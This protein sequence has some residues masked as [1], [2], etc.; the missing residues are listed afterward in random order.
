M[1]SLV[2]R[3]YLR[4]TTVTAA[5]VLC[6]PSCTCKRPCSTS[7]WFIQTAV[8][9]E[10]DS[11][12]HGCCISVWYAVCVC[13]CVLSLIITTLW[14][15]RV[16]CIC[17][18]VD[19]AI[20]SGILLQNVKVQQRRMRAEW[21]TGTVKG[22]QGVRRQYSAMKER[23]TG[24]QSRSSCFFMS[25]MPLSRL[26]VSQLLSKQAVT[27][28]P[29][30]LSKG[31]IQMHKH[32]HTCGHSCV[33]YPLRGCWGDGL[34]EGRHADWYHCAVYGGWGTNVHFA[35]LSSCVCLC[36]TVMTLIV[37]DENT[38]VCAPAFACFCVCVSC[39]YLSVSHPAAYQSSPLCLSVCINLFPPS[40]TLRLI[41]ASAGQRDGLWHSEGNVTAVT[42][43]IDT[44]PSTL[45]LGRNPHSQRRGGEQRDARR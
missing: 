5:A 2:Q 24:R 31:H 14:D 13:A 23:E 25:L 35:C 42:S 12:H 16:M 33:L 39:V 30:W 6:P 18:C 11:Q 29:S 4:R 27:P 15:F 41:H 34:K 44:L 26:F 7:W 20:G 40:L 1:H 9:S 3:S 19:G 43:E 37:K 45:A 22:E 28:I 21:D 17:A 36:T 32:A 8:Q 10:C 38:K